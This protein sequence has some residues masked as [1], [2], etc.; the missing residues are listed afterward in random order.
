MAITPTVQSG[1]PITSSR[2]S[3]PGRVAAMIATPYRQSAGVARAML[4]VGTVLTVLIA[5][6]AVF[7][8]LVAPYDFDQ[9]SDAGGRFPKQAAPSGTHLFGTS[10]QTFDVFSRVVWGART[11]LKVVVLSLVL[12]IVI[13]V[14]LGLVAGFV[15]GWLDR[16][17]V[18]VM[19]A[20]FAFPYLLLAIVVAFL[21]SDSLG[22][23]VTTAAAAITA[24]YIP[25]YFRVV[26]NSTVSAKQATYVEAARAL[27]AP[28]RTIMSRY[29]FTNVVQSVPVIATLNAAD[30]VGT[31]AAL[32]FLGYGIQPTEAAEW[33]YDLNRAMDDAASGIWWT[34]VFPG[35]AIVVLVMALTF[36]GEGLNETLNPTLRVRRL[37]PVVLPPRKPG[38]S[39]P[40]PAGSE[41]GKGARSGDGPVD[42]PGEELAGSE[43]GAK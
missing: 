21:L 31:L 4:V 29:L 20:L 9:V 12:T 17:L 32:G 5:L 15:G 42:R 8:P 37:V 34:G 3:L 16:V 30:A 36:V 13:G 10:V 7:A 24:V 27:G 2:R 33:G 23:G 28:P 26:R 35:L 43:E 25:Q 14:V 11:E 18:L 19:D 22:G 1:G 39:A 38:T 6:V 40:T 41:A